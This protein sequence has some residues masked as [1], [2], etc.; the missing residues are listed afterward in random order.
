MARTTTRCE[1]KDR[2]LERSRPYGPQYARTRRC[3]NDAA[4]TLRTREG[5]WPDEMAGRVRHFCDEHAQRF[6]GMPSWE[7]V[8]QQG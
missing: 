5:Y 1:H 3:G 2:T 6:A 7:Q 4:V 8:K